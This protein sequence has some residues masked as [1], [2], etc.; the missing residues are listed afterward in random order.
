M[1]LLFLLPLFISG[2][3]W[4]TTYVTVCPAPKNVPVAIAYK[5]DNLPDKATSATVIKWMLEDLVSCQANEQQ[6]RIIVDGYSQSS[7]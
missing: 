1:R 2:C 4:N 3:W 7:P 5:T 6:L